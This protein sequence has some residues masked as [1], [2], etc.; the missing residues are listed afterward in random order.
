MI[1]ASDW[2]TNTDD[3]E[4]NAFRE[5][6]ADNI[7][8][9]DDP[10]VGI[11]WY[12]TKADDLFGVTAID[13]DT[14]PAYRSNLFDKPVQTCKQLHYKIWAKEYHKGRDKRFQGDYT[15]VPRGRIFYVEGEGF[16]V[17]VGSWIKEYP[18]CKELVMIEF[19]LPEDSTRFEIDEHWE[20]GH[21]WSD[22]Y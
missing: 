10:K 18:S 7:D 15:Q 22:K 2:D 17:T 6:M 21:G 16:I 11:F 12:D 14:A 1:Y 9:Q 13:L 5:A 4:M 8:S 20:L 19:D 3:A